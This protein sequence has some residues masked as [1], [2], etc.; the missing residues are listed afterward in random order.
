VV[1]AYGRSPHLA[2]CLA[3][4]Q[5]QTSHSPVVVATSTPWD[6]LES[7]VAGFGATL[8]LHAPNAGIGR[9]WN[10]ALSQAS[11]RWVTIAHQDDI[12]YPRFL[13]E[14]LRVASLVPD[15]SLVVTDYD[16]LVGDRIRSAWFLRMKRMLMEAGFLGR[17]A[18]HSRRSKLNCLRLGNSIPCPAVTLNRVKAKFEFDEAMR[19]N[20][21]WKA[22]IELA[23]QDGAFVRVREH[24]M[25]H[26]I[27]EDSETSET[28]RSGHRVSEDKEIL[29]SLWPN[30]IARCIGRAYALAYLS[31]SDNLGLSK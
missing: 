29:E 13:E 23:K 10:F 28:L 7:L 20:L 9:D 24:L 26:R 18:I 21:D 12:Y 17:T 5:A 27:H 19:V 15:A 14:T 6:G 31:N 2:D 4:L 25:A 3:S 22:W 8:A 16:E 1:P 30:W 11:S